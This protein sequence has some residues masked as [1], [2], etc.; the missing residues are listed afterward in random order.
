MM[1]CVVLLGVLMCAS[2]LSAQSVQQSGNP[3][4]THLACWTTTGVIQDCG[5]PNNP[6]ATTAGFLGG[7]ICV[8]SA[9]TTGPYQQFCLSALSTG[10]QLSVQNYGGATAGGISF[11]I[12]GVAAGLATVNLPTVSGNFACFNNTS[13]GLTDCGSNPVPIFNPTSPPYN[14]V[15]DNSHDDTAAWTAVCNAVVSAGGGWIVSPPGKTYKIWP[16]AP[17]SGTALCNFGAT[18]GVRISMQGSQFNVAYTDPAKLTFMFLFE[19][20]SDLLIEDLTGTAGTGKSETTGPAWVT[21][22]N[23]SG[24]GFGC[25]NLRVARMNLNGGQIG[26]AVVRAQGT[27]QFSQNIHIDGVCANVYYCI[28]NEADGQNTDFDIAT[29]NAGRSYIGYNT[30]GIR[31]RINSV[32]SG[33]FDDVLIDAYAFQ[34]DI[35]ES[36]TAD[37]D[38]TYINRLSTTYPTSNPAALVSVRHGQA[39]PSHS[40]LP[41]VFANIHIHYDVILNGT[42]SVVAYD[43]GSQSGSGSSPVA[44]DDVGNRE[45]NI[46]IDGKIEGDTSSGNL[47]CFLSTSAPCAGYAGLTVGSYNVNNLLI[48]TSSKPFIIGTGAT[49]IFSNVVAPSMSSPTFDAGYTSSQT[50]YR[51]PV[52]FN[53]T[54]YSTLNT[55]SLGGSAITLGGSLTM[56]GAYTFTGN[57]TGNTSVTFPTSGTLVQ[58]VSPTFTGIVNTAAITA[59]NK[60][61]SNFSA[62]DAVNI[63]AS[64]PSGNEGVTVTN[65]SSTGNAATLFY[66]DGG[67]LGGFFATGSSVSQFGGANTLNLINLKTGSGLGLGGNNALGAFL[68]GA[69]GF[70]VGSTAVDAG[71]GNIS[72]QNGY[73][74]GSSPVLMVSATAPTISSGF[75]ATSPSIAASNGIAAFDINVGTSCSG[76]IG[77]LAMPA[78]TTGWACSFSDVTTPASYVISQTGGSTNTVTITSYS[79]TTG[80]AANFTA[81][82]HI[83]GHC[84]GY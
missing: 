84:V 30:T 64:A 44:G 66:N 17:T 70:Y 40:N 39:D 12:N 3:T 24:S 21:C 48:P 47:V 45:D 4:P 2:P 14:A 56:S 8:D 32:N 43:G 51:Q 35:S 73:K 23:N 72:P 41:S 31:G 9:S 60:I 65:T 53:G 54:M 68:S 77:A 78:A 34:G 74:L 20:G 25:R 29:N 27:G 18:S 67:L 83:R 22:S 75:C 57:L 82:D 13:G 55:L 11:L 76:S 5:T 33:P 38:I 63:S 15:G 50:T 49:V 37:V 58:T 79:R 16:T 61:T 1:A 7:P 42:T 28:A 26:V 46:I 69:N 10:G 52:N 62:A 6:F 71:A 59:S 19:G 80:L 81:S 36:R